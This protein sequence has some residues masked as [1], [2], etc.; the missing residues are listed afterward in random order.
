[1]QIS[2][3]DLLTPVQTLVTT[4]IFIPFCAGDEN[5]NESLLLRQ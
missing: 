1:M 4:F 5:A 2:G 3:G